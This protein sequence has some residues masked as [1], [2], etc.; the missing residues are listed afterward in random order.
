MAGALGVQL[1]GTAIYD[2]EM[3]TRAAAGGRASPGHSGRHRHRAPAAVGRDA[4]C[5]CRHRGGARA[6]ES[7]MDEI[8]FDRSHGG[9][10]PSGSVI[11]FSVST[12]PFGPP[13]EVLAAYH[14]AEATISSYPEPYAATLTAAIAAHLGVGARQ[15]S[16]RQRLNPAHLSDCARAASQAAL[17]GGTDLQ[18]DRQQPADIGYC[19]GANPASPRTRFSTR[20]RRC[21]PRNR[22]RRRRAVPGAAEQSRP[23]HWWIWPA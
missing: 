7:A 19:P 1:G 6:A 4:D 20:P 17:R 5:L 12:N 2:G 22:A 10:A 15:R 16:G 21:R 11:D 18:R 13:P 3:E 23:G 14:K 9:A 8:A